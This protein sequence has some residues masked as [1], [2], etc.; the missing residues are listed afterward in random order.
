MV[1]T[2]GRSPEGRLD[3]RLAELAARRT[4]VDDPNV[5]P[6]MVAPLPVSQMETSLDDRLAIARRDLSAQFGAEIRPDRRLLLS[7]HDLSQ[8]ADA[9]VQAYLVRHS[10]DIT[11]LQ[12]RDLVSEIVRT[13]FTLESPGQCYRNT[14]VVETAIALIQPLVLG[15]LNVASTVEVPRPE[16]EAQL[17]SLVPGLLTENEIH[18]NQTEQ[19][20]LIKLLIADVLGLGPLEPLIADESVSDITVNGPKQVY[21]ERRGRVELTGVTFRDDQHLMTI[22]TRIVTRIGRHIDESQPLVVGRLFD[23]SL[24]KIMIPPL[25]FDGPAISIRKFSKKTITLDTMASNGSISAAMATLLKIAARCRLNILIS[26]V[27]GSGKTTLLSAMT[28]AFDSGE[29]VVTIE[30]SPELQVQAPHVLRLATH[31]DMTPRDLLH[32]ALPWRWDRIIIGEWPGAEA[33]DLLSGND[34]FMTTISALDPRDALARLEWMP[35]LNIPPQTI[36]AR[37]ASVINLICHIDRMSD[38]VR[39]VTRITEIIGVEGNAIKT[40]DLF[41]YEFEG[42]D[43][44]D[45]L[46]RG[47]FHSCGV[48]PVFLPRAEYYG[49]DR[50]LLEVIAR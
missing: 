38:G 34:G 41:A 36:R 46:L 23:G 45:G 21:V 12:Y 28:R 43:G 3:D 27:R 31:G 26:G 20:E 30:D 42:N 35:G 22:C 44:A 17:A 1:T 50:A 7:R 2:F 39:R 19:G 37:I 5:L 8:I 24:V 49:L 15:R 33:L 18:L 9:R 10:L 48:R 32:D 40:Q 4:R 14:A 16:V 29:H 6:E 25:T 13:L 47:T 11:P